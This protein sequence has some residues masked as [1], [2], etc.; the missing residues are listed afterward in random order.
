MKGSTLNLHI[1]DGDFLP[2][3]FGQEF[4]P[5]I[6]VSVNGGEQAEHTKAV[7]PPNNHTP[8]WKEILPFDIAYPTDTIEIKIINAHP[9]A[10]ADDKEIIAYSFMIAPPEDDGNKEYQLKNQRPVELDLGIQDGNGDE[11]AKVRYQA[12]WIYNKYNFLNDLKENM[13]E[14]RKALISEMRNFDNRMQLISKPFGGYKNIIEMDDVHLEDP[15]LGEKAKKWLK[16]SH[17]EEAVNATFNKVTNSIGMKNA[18]WGRLAIYMF[19]LWSML[20]CFTCI[21]KADFLNLTIAILGL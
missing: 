7:K 17:R 16:V 3:V 8:N 14:E 6:T 12:T 10:P 2:E 5:M 13:E 19:G 1:L 9:R 15:F 11:V 18:R 20:C 4:E 21:Q